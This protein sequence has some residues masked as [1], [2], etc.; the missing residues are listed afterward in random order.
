MEDKELVDEL[1][2]LGM[3]YLGAL[4]QAWILIYFTYLA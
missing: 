4:T 1:F 2:M 3:A